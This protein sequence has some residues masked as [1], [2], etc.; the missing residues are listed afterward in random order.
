MNYLEIKN[1]P[2]RAIRT[3]IGVIMILVA[4]SWIV[5]YYDDRKV[6][7]LVLA[8][9]FILTGIYHM[10][11]GFGIERSW[12]RAEG[13]ILTIKWIDRLRV[14]RIPES[15]VESICLGRYSI[16]FNLKDSKPFKLKLGYMGMTDKV[17]LYDFFTDYAKDRGL[18][19]FR[20]PDPKK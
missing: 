11:E 18:V 14:R 10:T 16:I 13:S 19:I 20:N 12:I 3:G 2:Y 8:I 6:F 9:T 1:K 7:D 5:L 17:S 15:E 4:V